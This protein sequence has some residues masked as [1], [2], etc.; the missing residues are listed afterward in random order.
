[1]TNNKLIDT[2]DGLNEELKCNK[3]GRGTN[4]S[5]TEL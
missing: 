4:L 5:E 2:S 3:T 1:M